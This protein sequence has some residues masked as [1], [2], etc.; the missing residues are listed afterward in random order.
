MKNL[1]K[2]IDTK[3]LPPIFGVWLAL[4]A[5]EILL[6]AGGAFASHLLEGSPVPPGPARPPKI[7]HFRVRGGSVMYYFLKS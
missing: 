5:Q 4:A 3:I 2:T 7:G 6:K 1:R